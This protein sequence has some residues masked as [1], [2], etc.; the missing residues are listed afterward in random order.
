M[1]RPRLTRRL[2]GFG[3]SLFAEVTALARPCPAPAAPLDA[4][5]EVVVSEP[6]YDAYLPGI[7]MAQAEARVVPL[8]PPA[9]RLDL[10]ALKAAISEKTRLLLVHSPP[11]PARRRLPP[12]A[13]A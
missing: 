2:D 5:D 10:A 13:P 8:V 12:P 3:T 6:F 4:A 9:F 1:D 11:H 7:A